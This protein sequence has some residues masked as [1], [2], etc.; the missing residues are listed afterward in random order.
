MTQTSINYATVLYELGIPGEAISETADILKMSG[1]LVESL[2][3]PVIEL[4]CK[5]AVIDRIF[6]KEMH[7]FLK[8]LCRN[9]SMELFREIFEAYQTYENEQENRLAAVLYY[10]EPPDERQLKG[11][12]KYLMERFH[13]KSVALNCVFEPQLIGGFI[14]CAGDFEMDRSV[15]GKV[16]QL[17]QKLVK[18]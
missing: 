18:R 15:R 12:K 7:N 8:V 9:Q 2:T 5:F 4:K 1:P 13:C 11:I 3:S 16:H 6:P 17:Q 14:L 10:V